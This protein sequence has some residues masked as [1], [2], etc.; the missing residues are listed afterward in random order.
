MTST[1][2]PLGTHSADV[3]VFAVNTPGDK[4]QTVVSSNL[5]ANGYKVVPNKIGTGGA[6]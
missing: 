2:R 3:A 5:Q 4:A 1:C 6:Q